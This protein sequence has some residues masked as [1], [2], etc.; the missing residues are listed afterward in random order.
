[1]GSILVFSR[2]KCGLRKV[3][4]FFGLEDFFD[5]TFEFFRVGV[6]FL[7]FGWEIIPQ[8]WALVCYAFPIFFHRRPAKS[9]KLSLTRPSSNPVWL[10]HF[11]QFEI[12]HLG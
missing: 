7:D 3:R 9:N 11:P 12:W 2:L 5:V 4:L 1:M 10:M 6:Q 8:L